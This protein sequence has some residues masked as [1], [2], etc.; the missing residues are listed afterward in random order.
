MNDEI[1]LYNTIFIYVSQ[2][3]TFVMLVP[4]GIAFYYKKYWNLHLRRFAYYLLVSFLFAA[5]IQG[6][7]WLTSHYYVT[8]KPYMEVWNIK[9]TNF[10]II[11]GSIQTFGFLGKYIAATFKNVTWRKVIQVVSLFLL[12]ASLVDYFFIGDFR[13]IS[14][15][16]TSIV[17]LFTI[18]VPLLHSWHL[19]NLLIPFSHPQEHI[20]V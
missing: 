17:A 20:S 6:F 12:G 2:A 15:V 11:L 14:T 4:V 5:L 9:N 8:C 10:L 3:L 13:E 16:S 7:I 19:F 18:I 1:I